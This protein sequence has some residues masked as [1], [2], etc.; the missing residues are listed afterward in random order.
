M[1]KPV[2]KKINPENSEKSIQEQIFDAAG[3]FLL[4]QSSSANTTL[5]SLLSTITNA[6]KEDADDNLGSSLVILSING[7]TELAKKLS[8]KIDT[9]NLSD[10]QHYEILWGVANNRLPGG[11]QSSTFLI[12]QHL[13]EKGLDPS[14]K[15]TFGQTVLGEIAK[16][17]GAHLD[18][19]IALV[20]YFEKNWRR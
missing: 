15:N 12:F 14:K 9:R 4:G 5:N 13:L 6:I 1:S 20:I 16:Q 18:T 11:E 7:Q 17:F 3:E 10:K 2:S 8:D 19:E